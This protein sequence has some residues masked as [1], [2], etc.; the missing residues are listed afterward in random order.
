MFC[1]SGKC[2]SQCPVSNIRGK[3]FSLSPYSMVLAMGLSQS[4]RLGLEI[5]DNRF[6]ISPQEDPRP[7][8]MLYL[9]RYLEILAVL[10]FSFPSR[11][12]PYPFPPYSVPHSSTGLYGLHW[13]ISLSSGFL[14]GL[15]MG[16]TS[17][18]LEYRRVR[19]GIYSP[20]SL[21]AGSTWVDCVPLWE[22]LHMTPSDHCSLKILNYSF[23]SIQA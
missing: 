7:S 21:P 18:R 22:T 13:W 17:A 8:I 3:V 23:F 16:G 1:R 2:L 11:S 6:R 14:L 12:C 15:P 4:W 10:I 19:M 20:A 5:L 9:T